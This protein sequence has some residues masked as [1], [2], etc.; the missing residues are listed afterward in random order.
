MPI[1]SGDVES[2]VKHASAVKTFVET[3]HVKP[4]KIN[5]D[6]QKV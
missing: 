4:D 1:S 2:A 6:E 5:T 3:I